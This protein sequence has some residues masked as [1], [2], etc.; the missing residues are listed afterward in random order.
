M[1]NIKRK[2]GKLFLVMFWDFLETRKCCGLITCYSVAGH[3]SDKER[4]TSIDFTFTK[5]A[6]KKKHL[7]WHPNSAK[8]VG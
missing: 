4:I 6:K 3:C 1:V 5:N 2:R 8:W 7:A